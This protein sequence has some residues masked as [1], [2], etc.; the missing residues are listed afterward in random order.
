MKIKDGFMMHKVG[1][2]AVVVAVGENTKNFHGM[3]NLN[4]TGEF[5][6]KQL[7]N[8]RTKEELLD[9]MDATYNVERSEAEKGL[10]GFLEKLRAAGVLQE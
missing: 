4:K 2:R 8:D 5:L 10:E 7:E 1:N 6:W 9:A 3:I